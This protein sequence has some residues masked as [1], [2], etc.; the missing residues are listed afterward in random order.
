MWRH[1]LVSLAHRMLRQ[2]DL[3]FQTSLGYI[4]RIYL[5]KHQGRKGERE[6]G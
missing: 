6:G 4:V 2:E 5:K 1:R 3:T